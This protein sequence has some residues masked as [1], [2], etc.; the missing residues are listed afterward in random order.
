MKQTNKLKPGSG[1]LLVFILTAG[2]FGIIN[3]E[4][5]V[6]GIL[7]LIA[8]HFHVTVP[9]AGWTVSIFA[10]VVAISAPI[11]P[12]LFS[13]IN[14]KKVMLLALGVFTL[15]NIIS[16][17]TSNF[18]ILLIARALPAFLH[19]VYVSMAFTVAAASVSKEKAPK[20]VAKVFIGVSA[21]MVLGVPVTS[22]IA[23]E[24]SF[25]MGMMFFTVVNALVF[26]ATLLFVPSM[27]VKEK[28]S[29]GTQLNVLKKK[30]IWYSI[31]AVTLIN[32]ALFGFFSYMSDYLRTVTEVSY[33][34]ISIL[35]M[36]YGLANIIG[37]VIAG[38]QLATNP[39]RSMIFI[40][41]ALFTFYICIFILGEWLAAMT[42][43]ILILGILAGY[44][45]NTM[46]YM[47]TEAAPEA[48]DFANG[49]FL[50]SA[51]LGTTVGTAACGA[52]ITFF[53]TRYSVIGS[54]LFLA[55]SI[56]FVVLRIRTVQSSKTMGLKV[57]A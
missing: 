21:G 47:I 25:T 18:T 35:L 45:Q 15:S 38:K 54:S 51:N 48:P 6:I 27:P 40:P 37:N 17:L 30:I 4:M 13:G 12:L 32:G 39:I 53:D 5:G 41:F 1:A 10:L 20:A 19:P 8:E 43:I 9:E 28:L 44:G 34:V 7:P 26:M 24:V 49:L 55:V 52:F 22:Y 16:M 14:R 56:V 36:I 3:T 50:L 11:M 29:Y 42:V 31:M 2:V 46:Q 57:A 33:S 23:S